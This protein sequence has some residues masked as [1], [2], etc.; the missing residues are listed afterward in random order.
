MFRL[1]YDMHGNRY[2][3]GIDRTVVRRTLGFRLISNTWES[4]M[5]KGVKR[6]KC[7]RS[8]RRQLKHDALGQ[9]IRRERQLREFVQETSA[10]K[11]YAIG[12]CALCLGVSRGIVM[13]SVF[14]SQRKLQLGSLA[15]AGGVSGAP[16]A[17]HTSTR[18]NS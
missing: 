15:L 3:L 8:G 10:G 6:A 13:L 4:A 18:N 11:L 17:S 12:F 9:S 2:P 14:G 1:A 5:G 16:T 7:R